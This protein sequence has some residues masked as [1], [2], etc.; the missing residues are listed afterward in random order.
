MI[1]WEEHN[2]IGIITMD[3]PGKN[4][5]SVEDMQAFV[6]SIELHKEAMQGL[7]ITG[8]NQSFCSGL[9]LKDNQFAE[10]FPLL[11]KLLLTL[12]GLDVPVV[13]AMPGYAIGAGFLIM[14]CADQVYATESTRSKFG[15]PEVKLDLGIDELMLEIL[16]ERLNQKQLKQLILTGDYVTLSTLLE[17][18]TIDRLYDSDEEMINSAIS[19]IENMIS[20]SRSYYFT[21]RLLKRKKYSEIRELFVCECWGKLLELIEDK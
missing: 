3:A 21:K 20:H 7:I 13:C 5:L 12:Y 8:K 16:R 10:A 18:K 17:W 14:C 19:F 6:E 15:L 9:S 2:G 4:A 11:D 1:L